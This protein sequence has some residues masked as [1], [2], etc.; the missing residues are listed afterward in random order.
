MEP[1]LNYLRKKYLSKADF[2]NDAGNIPKEMLPTKRE[3]FIIP[4]LAIKQ[5]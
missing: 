1:L 3:L 5:A 2:V 4:N